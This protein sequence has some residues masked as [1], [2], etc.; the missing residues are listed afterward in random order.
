M[1]HRNRMIT[2]LPGPIGSPVIA[3]TAVISMVRYPL[4]FRSGHSFSLRSIQVGSLH[5]AP[6]PACEGAL[7]CMARRSFSLEDDG[8]RSSTYGPAGLAPVVHQQTPLLAKIA[9]PIAVLPE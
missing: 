3:V 9:S 8:M 7:T 5:P 1:P 2:A 6:S 4:Y